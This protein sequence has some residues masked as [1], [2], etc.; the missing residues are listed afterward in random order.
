MFL[1]K[2]PFLK[3]LV[4]NLINDLVGWKIW[5]ISIIWGVVIPGDFSK[6]IFYPPSTI[7][8]IIGQEYIDANIDSTCGWLGQLPATKCLQYQ[9]L[10]GTQIAICGYL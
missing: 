5:M 4:L 8:Q 10:P 2:Y 3:V 9:W 1:H 6:N 7:E